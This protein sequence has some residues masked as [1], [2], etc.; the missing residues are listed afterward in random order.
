MEYEPEM[1]ILSDEM[2]VYSLVDKACGLF[3]GL[4][5]D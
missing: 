4:V 1:E 3:T 2:V 5:G